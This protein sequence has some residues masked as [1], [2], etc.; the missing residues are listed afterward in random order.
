MVGASPAF[1][2]PGDTRTAILQSL[3]LAKLTDLEFGSIIPSAT[4]GTVSVNANNDARTRTGGVTLAGT[5]AY[6]ARFLTYGTANAILLITRGALPV[7]SRVGGGATMNVD[8]LTLNGPALRIL[9][10]AG[11]V[12]VRY[13]GRLRVGANQMAGTYRGTFTVT[14]TYF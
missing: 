12:D 1:A 5:G 7:L 9:N 3:T 14:V 6:A 13:G 2:A 8:Q 4:A 10:A 11:V